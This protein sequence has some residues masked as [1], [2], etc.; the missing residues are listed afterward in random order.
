MISGLFETFKSSVWTLTY[1]EFRSLDSSLGNGGLPSNDSSDAETVST[2]PDPAANALP[3]LDTQVV[4]A[5]E[6]ADAELSQD[7]SQD[8]IDAAE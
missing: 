5:D 3:P 1:R 2:S 6:D 8:E 4:N 7:N